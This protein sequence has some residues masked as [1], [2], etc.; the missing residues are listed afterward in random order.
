MTQRLLPWAIYMTAAILVV[1]YV[2]LFPV[3]QGLSQL[4]AGR[5]LT[6]APIVAAL[7]VP[8]LLMIRRRRRWLPVL[9]A[10][11]FAAGGLLLADPLFP[12]KRI[13]VAEYM[14][15]AALLR[16]A[17]PRSLGAW[18]RTMVAAMAGALFGMHDEMIQGLLPERTFGLADLAVNACGA[19]AGALLVQGGSGDDVK[20]EERLTDLPWPFWAV[21]F[22]VVL[23]AVALPAF[24]DRALPLWSTAPVLAAAAA[25]FLLP[26]PRSAALR[27][28]QVLVVV[29][30]VALALYPVVTHVAPLSFR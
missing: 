30:G 1:I 29:L 11:A 8:L 19:A 4:A 24:R 7:A 22:G 18:Q 21:L 14:L 23:E 27:H 6:V 15:L 12:A 13:H 26:P 20:P 2:N 17:A 9:L 5:G 28:V 25:C 3:W 16:L 10:L